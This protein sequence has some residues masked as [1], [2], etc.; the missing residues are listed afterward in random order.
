MAKITISD[1]TIRLVA[2]PEDNLWEHVEPIIKRAHAARH[3]LQF[4]KY[5]STR[6]HAIDIGLSRLAI[7]AGVMQELLELTKEVSS[8]S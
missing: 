6:S 4:K 3:Y 1:V 8:E 7:K 5:F 2:A